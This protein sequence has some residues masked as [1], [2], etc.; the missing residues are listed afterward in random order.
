[1]TTTPDS[2]I[3]RTEAFPDHGYGEPETPDFYQCGV[4]GR[5]FE[6]LRDEICMDCQI[7]WQARKENEN[8]N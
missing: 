1:M 7:Q 8:D 4:C 2:Y 6:Y 5:Q 3:E